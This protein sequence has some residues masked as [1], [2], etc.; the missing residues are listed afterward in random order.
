VSAVDLYLR[1]QVARLRDLA[2]DELIGVYAG[3]S[4]ALGGYE[5]GRSDVDIA[6]V[7]R[8]PPAQPL[9][10]EIVAA[11]RH[12]SLSCPARGLELVLYWLDAVA[13][14]SLDAAFDLNLNDE[15]R[16]RTPCSFERPAGRRSDGIH[17]ANEPERVPGRP[18]H[19]CTA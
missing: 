4:L 10:E 6:G 15:I 5:P 16:C 18:S 3:G 17:G 7:V 12:E 19:G 14:P 1:E 11:L 9:K 13:E 8:S 2:G